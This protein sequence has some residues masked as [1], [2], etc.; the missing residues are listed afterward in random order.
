MLLVRAAWPLPAGLRWETP[1][2]PTAAGPSS[3]LQTQ[4]SA[5]TVPRSAAQRWTTLSIPPGKLEVP[6]VRS[7]TTGD[8]N[9]VGMTGRCPTVDIVMNGRKVRGLID[10]GSEVTTVTE[11]WVAE[12]LQNSDLLPMTQV[13]L[14]AANGL[15]IPY[16]GVVIVDLELLGQKCEG[17]P[18]L[19]VKD[20]SDPSTRKKKSDVPALVGMNVLG[21]LSSL[22]N[23]LDIV[24]PVLQPAVR[25]IRL[26]RT[27][28]RGVA[29]VAGQTLIP[30]HSLVTLRITGVQ[31][32]SR[33]LL[34]SPLAQPLPRGLLLIP[35]LV[36]G[37]AT[38]RCVRLANLSAEDYILARR[39]P[40]VVLHAVDGIESDEGVQITT[41]CNEMTVSM[42]PS[43]AESTPSD[44]VPC[45]AFDGTDDERARLHALLNQY[46]HGFTQDDLDL[47]YTEAV[48]H[49]IPTS[50]DAPV[51]QP[52]RSIPPNQL[53]E[54][55]EHIKGLL[56]QRVI[57][58]SHSPYAAPV[59]LVRKKDGSL[60]LCVDYR[61]LNLKTVGDAYPLP[62]IQESLDALVGA[63]YFS[64]LDLASGYHQIS[65]DPRD[66]HKTAFTTPFGLYEYTRMPMGLASAPATFQRLMQATMSDFAF[67]FLLVYLDDLLVYSKT[68]DEHMEHLERLLQRVTETG[69]KLKAS[70]FLRREV[71]YLGHT[72][73]ADGVSCESG[74]VEYVQNWPTPTTTT[75]L[76]SFLGFASYYR[77]F[78]SGF[79]RIAGPLHDLVSDGAKCSK[80]K[81]ADVSRLWG[82]KHQEAF[83]S[84]KEAMTTAPV[85][86]YADYT[87]PFILETDA[88]HDGLSA[89]LSQEQDGK[90]KVITDNNPLTYFRSA[91][92]GALE[93]RWASQLAQFDFD[94]QYRPG[95]INP[96]DALSRMPLEPSPEPLLTVVPPEVATVNDLQCEQLA[97]DP[98]LS[99]G[100][101]GDTMAPVLPLDK[102][103]E[104]DQTAVPEAATEVLPRLS[105]ADLQQLQQQ[106]PVLG[107]VLAAWPTKP[108]NTKE[109]SMRA[110]VQQYPRLFLK[111]G[112]LH[113]RLSDQRR[114]T[115]E[116]LVLPSSL[117]PD[118]LASL[119]NDMGHQGY[120]RTMELLRPR[121]YWPAMYREVRDYISSCERCTMGHAPALHTTSSHLLASHPLEILAIDFTKLETASDG[122]ENV[123]VLT[124]VFSKFTQAIP[125]RNQEAGTVAKV[126]VH[127]RVVPALR[128]A[129]KIHSDQGRDCE[130]KL[131][132]SLCELYGIK[133]TRTTPYHPRG[134]AQ[135]ERFNRS[136]HDLLRTLPPEQ[137]S[138]W[139]QYLP[140]LVQAYN[141]T[142]HTSTG[143]S[144]HFLLFGQE[145]Q[146]PVDHLLG[147]TTTSAVGPTDWVRQHRLRLQASHARALKHLQEAAAE[148]RKQT[149]QKAADH[150]LHVGDLV[151]LRNRVLGRSKIQDR[152]RPE[153]HVVTARRH[154]CVWGQ[155]ILWWAGAEPQSGWRVACQ[156]TIGCCR[157]GAD[158]GN[159]C[160]DQPTVP[161]SGWVLA[162]SACDCWLAS[163]R[164]HASSRTH[165]CCPHSRCTH[166]RCTHSCSWRTASQSQTCSQAFHPSEQRGK[167]QCCPHSCWSRSRCT[168]S[169]S[170]RTA[171]QS[172]TCTQAFHPS[173]QRGKHQC[174]PH[175]CWSRSRCT[176]SCSWRT[177]SQSQTCTQELH[178]C[179]QRGKPQCC[180]PTSKSNVASVMLRCTTVYI[181]FSMIELW[182]LDR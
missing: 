38:Q 73:S 150:P 118:V 108:S 30:A 46:A 126:L 164:T 176:H 145:P 27:S 89:I 105:L 23:N 17:V 77:R 91:K 147:R 26:E 156:G 161:W 79:A 37:D 10:T 20:S 107:P 13:T 61:R 158:T 174:C 182:W 9:P 99:A 59:V 98:T 8:M 60:R 109:R 142:P 48:Q 175:S 136:L 110:L 83:D 103:E 160:S 138:K 82:P 169:C 120:G 166:S 87:K 58:E 75:E 170:W 34:A 78:I 39:T 22:L 43:I 14:K 119:H 24:P 155:T 116:Q 180:Q 55:K 94:I 63:Q 15:E 44:A 129:Q 131:V 42:E 1:V 137:K 114:G 11:R 81:A 146:L 19:V 123:L 33:H 121:V 181:Y 163:C 102:E 148:R 54:V 36:S 71:T 152:W 31:R 66:Q 85:L 3:L 32:P 125:T 35:T 70:K 93:Q 171:S 141:N 47:G 140:E 2:R 97:V 57:V 172:Q 12:N 168:H 177:A 112:V 139:P 25:E 56:A 115:L 4:P 144:P 130:S 111:N 179:E 96:A 101:L 173:E 29:R 92:L 65:M 52:Y 67:Q 16:S 106:D 72:I 132:K 88:S 104:P 134:N 113:R 7:Q 178:P 122:R 124:D 18:V 154:T 28:V 157:R 159:T 149:D 50:D 21:R 86:G 162:G 167:H 62:R 135:C 51:V 53:Q 64:T 165:S 80:K 90:F 84:L 128:G 49:H 127:R 143:F 40:V 74:K 133:K 95:K 69:L 45:P 151:Y 41:T 6:V 5:A 76:R 100:V 68:F 117:R 153:L